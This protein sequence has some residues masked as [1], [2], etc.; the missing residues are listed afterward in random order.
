M[1]KILKANELKAFLEEYNISQEEFAEVVNY[2]RS[3]LQGILYEEVKLGS[4][5]QIDFSKA[6]IKLAKEKNKKFNP[7]APFGLF[8]LENNRVFAQ[9]VYDDVAEWIRTEDVEKLS[10]YW[11][12]F[13]SLY[14]LIDQEAAIFLIHCK[15]LISSNSKIDLRAELLSYLQSFDCSVAS[16]QKVL[17]IIGVFLNRENNL[18]IRKPRS[19]EKYREKLI[20]EF[21][22]SLYEDVD[23]KKGELVYSHLRFVNEMDDIY[24]DLL[25]AYILVRADDENGEKMK[26]VIEKR[27]SLIVWACE[28]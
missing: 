25:V 23:P 12:N 2:S 22:R 19:Q 24:W 11:R 27:E 5:I 17:G 26:R 10:V 6:A 15:K 3:G 8:E 18:K 21:R 4:K 13:D 28:T 20:E 9:I 16:V 1:A 14:G 7:F